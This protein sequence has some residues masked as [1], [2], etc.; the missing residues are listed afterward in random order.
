MAWRRLFEPML[1]SIMLLKV[2]NICQDIKCLQLGPRWIHRRRG[3]R[4][5]SPRARAASPPTLPPPTS[6]T[7]PPPDRQSAAATTAASSER[8]RPAAN[9]NNDNKNRG[10]AA[11]VKRSHDPYADFRSSMAEM[12][13]RRPARPRRR[14]SSWRGTCPSTRRGTT[15]PS[16]TSSL[17]LNVASLSPC[18]FRENMCI[19]MIVDF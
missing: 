10:A 16:A 12:V 18:A 13:A 15:P 3:R 19:I 14:R 1:R 17:L 7:T 9:H 5:S 11:V 2:H 6:T 4:H 8:S